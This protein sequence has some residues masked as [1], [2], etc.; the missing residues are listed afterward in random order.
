MV[1]VAVQRDLSVIA[2]RLAAPKTLNNVVVGPSFEDWDRAFR[3]SQTTFD[4]AI[5]QSFDSSLRQEDAKTLDSAM[6]D[7]LC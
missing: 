6:V 5:A 3:Q 1:T 7:A 4:G 2:I